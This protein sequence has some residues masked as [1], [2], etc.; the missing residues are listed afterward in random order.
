MTS[1][2]KTRRWMRT[3]TAASLIARAGYDDRMDY[4]NENMD[5]YSSSWILGCQLGQDGG[6]FAFLPA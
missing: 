4:D 6:R 3:K 2:S 1:R 5:L